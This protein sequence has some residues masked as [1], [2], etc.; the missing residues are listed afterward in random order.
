M[1]G[2][3]TQRHDRT[4]ITVGYT[5]F[6][7]PNYPAPGLVMWVICTPSNHRTIANKNFRISVESY[8]FLGVISE[9]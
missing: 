5:Y 1:L 9:I 2:S 7:V 3:V 8:S 4:H 6:Q